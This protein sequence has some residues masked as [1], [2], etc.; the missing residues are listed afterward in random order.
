MADVA[1]GRGTEGR[2]FRISY[3]ATSPT[4]LSCV[5]LT[6]VCVGGA[7]AARRKRNAPP[8]SNVQSIG[9]QCADEAAAAM[10]LRAAAAGVSAPASIGVQCAR[11]QPSQL[12]C[13]EDNVSYNA[14]A[15]TCARAGRARDLRRAARANGT[16]V[17]QLTKKEKRQQ[18]VADR[19]EKKAVKKD[20]R[21]EAA[22]EKKAARLAKK[23]AAAAADK[24]QVRKGAA[25]G[26]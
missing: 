3:L 10:G 18:V 19:K 11:P 24:K 8:G 15:A 9:I 4:G 2:L 1:S 17:E 20:A 6:K 7:L 22:A 16:T 5:G 23:A 12:M 25:A 13:T 21:K 14:L 26:R